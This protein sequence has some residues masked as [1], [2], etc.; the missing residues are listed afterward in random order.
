VL[1][2]TSNP[3]VNMGLV[4]D[5][6]GDSAAE[7]QS[8][9]PFAHGVFRDLFDRTVLTEIAAEFPS[10]DVMSGSF[11]GEIQG[12]KFTESNWEA[13]GPVTQQFVSACN[14]GPFLRALE[15]LT[16]F[17]GL[18]SDP[19]LAGGG[20]HQTG[21]GGRLKVHSDFNVHPF[22]NLTR[23]INMLV[24]LNEPWNED[25]GGALELW[26]ADMSEAVE[27]VAPD[28]GTVVIFTCSDESFHGLPDPLRCPEGTFR[29][30]LAF[31]YFTADAHVPDARSTLWKERPGEDFLSRPS[32]RMKASLGHFRRGVQTVF[33]GV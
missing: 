33:R 22:L 20:M 27:T 23:R 12:G 17:E 32:Q 25:W 14:S 24:Y 16:G 10:S 2:T 11:K 21:R 6:F 8:A 18:L 29:K 13:F 30:S 7:Y 19:F 1:R 31:Y 9:Q 28:L 3:V 5:R 26:N 15:T 4:R